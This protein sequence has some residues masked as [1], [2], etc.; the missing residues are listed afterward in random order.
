MK[1]WKS[2]VAALTMGSLLMF[3]SGCNE[4]A[5]TDNA[6]SQATSAATESQVATIESSLDQVRQQLTGVWMGGA[7]IDQAGF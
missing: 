5:P 6:S 7:A 2:N 1:V 3:S 4:P